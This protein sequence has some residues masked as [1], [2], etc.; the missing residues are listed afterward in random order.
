LA[1]E[2]S[3]LY[4]RA[5]RL[6]G[7]RDHTRFALRVKLLRKGPSQAVEEVL[8]RLEEE[9]LL[10]DQAVALQRALNRRQRGLWGDRRI[11]QDLKRLG[12]DARMIPGVLE[13]VNRE[14]KEEQSL[15]EAIE[16]WVGRSGKPQAAPQLKKLFDRCVRL[17]YVPDLVRKQLAPYFQKINWED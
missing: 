11:V 7:R 16:M 8:N 1:P 3:L 6:L 5:L 17:G 9:G 10:N 2:T 4:G 12:I 13:Q 14:K 15:Q